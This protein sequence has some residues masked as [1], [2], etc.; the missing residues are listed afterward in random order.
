MKWV[1]TSV[2][3]VISFVSLLVLGLVPRVQA[4]QCSTTSFKG[5]YGASCEGAIV[6]VGP[7]AVV[8]VLTADGKGNISGV[9]T[10][11]VNGEISQGVTLTGAYTVNANCTGSIVTTT[12]D[13]AVT[14]HDFVIDANKSVS[15]GSSR[16]G[17]ARE[18]LHQRSG[19]VTGT[20][21]PTK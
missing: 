9:E 3:F 11:S 20:I 1:I 16:G 18:A 6:G 5:A 21:L 8:S 13:G 17:E 10:L 19:A 12:P 4:R 14:D 15:E 7:V 2:G